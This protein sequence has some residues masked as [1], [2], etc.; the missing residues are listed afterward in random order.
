MPT[1]S[2][3]ELVLAFDSTAPLPLATT[4]PG[5]WYTDPRIA[6][7]ERDAVWHRTWQMVGR[8][9]QVDE[10]GRFFTAEVG[11]EPIVVVRGKDGVLRAFFNVCRHHAAAVCTAK[12]GRAER[13]CCPYHGWVY[14]LDGRWK[15]APEFEGVENFDPAKNGLVPVAVATWEQLVFVHVAPDPPPLEQHLGGL[16]AR[17]RPLG[18]GALHH[19]ARREWVLGCNWKVFV[20][21][22]LDGGYHVPCLHRGLS[23]ILSYES[24]TIETFDR[25]C[26]Q[27]SPIDASG[28]ESMTAA[29]RKGQAAYYWLYPNLM[30]SWYEGYLDTNLVVP[31][32]VDRMKVVFDF[33]FAD[34]GEAARSKN[35]HSMKVSERIQDEDHAICESVQR[36]LKSRAYGAGRLSV[37]R[38]GGENLFHRLLAADLRRELAGRDA[39]GGPSGM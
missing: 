34:I 5:T 11:G 6:D 17:V 22:Y 27:S 30:L 16:V 14:G 33:Y 9:A 37:R 18:L 23:S 21:N 24:Y 39:R 26:L 3:E 13:L 20:D 7:L 29:V 25:A 4:A 2:L 31:L 1:D 12:E 28:G 35:E 19:A 8:V 36:G 32:D 15:S 10:P 38:E